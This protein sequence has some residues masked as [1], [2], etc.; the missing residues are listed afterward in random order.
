MTKTK[1]NW[2]RYTT[3]YATLRGE[4]VVCDMRVLHTDSTDRIEVEAC[5]RR[6]GETLTRRE[7]NSPQGPG[8]HRENPRTLRA[9]A[10]HMAEGLLPE[11]EAKASVE[12]AELERRGGQ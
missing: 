1:T 2:R 10:L 4:G 8:Y 6:T 7:W 5:S 11:A 3:D 12:A 9:M